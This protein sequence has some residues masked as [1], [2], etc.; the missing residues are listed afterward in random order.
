MYKLR[1][2]ISVIAEVGRLVFEIMSGG[3]FVWNIE[4]WQIVE[5]EEEG[6]SLQGMLYIVR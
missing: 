3:D 2:G 6:R 5:E 1:P 4:G